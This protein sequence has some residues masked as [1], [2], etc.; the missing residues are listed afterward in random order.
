MLKPKPRAG[1]LV[2]ANYSWTKPDVGGSD[3]LWG[4]LINADLDGIDSTVK[5]VSN[6][7][8]AAYPASNPS[9]Y[10][11]AGQVTA[12]LGSYLPLQGVTNGADAPAGQIGEVI[13]SNVASPGVTLTTAVVAN[14]TSIALSAG[15]WDVQGEVWPVMSA[16]ATIVVAAISAT[17]GAASLP[18]INASRNTLSFTS[19]VLGSS[20]MPLRPCRVSLTAPATY[21]LIASVTFASGTCTAFGNILARRAR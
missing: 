14:V 18:G 16:A 7:A 3:D 11:T 2:T 19:P 20:A 21:Y 17:S 6:V 4:G 13:S 9:G 12:S 5:G 15:D 1:E 8:N 10:Q